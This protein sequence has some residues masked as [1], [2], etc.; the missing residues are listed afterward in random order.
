MD[1]H[2]LQSALI[3]V[4]PHANLIGHHLGYYLEQILR[5]TYLPNISIWKRSFRSFHYTLMRPLH[6]TVE[7][8]SI[9][10]GRSLAYTLTP[11]V[12]PLTLLLLLHC[13]KL[14]W[15][16]CVTRMRS[17]RYSYLPITPFF[18]STH[19]SLREGYWRSV[20]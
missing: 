16:T 3:L 14:R 13:P 6:I 20:R 5:L 7:Y 2:K 10:F 15:I 18:F 19:I 17:P 4:D 1:D 11:V 12:L 8:I 9:L